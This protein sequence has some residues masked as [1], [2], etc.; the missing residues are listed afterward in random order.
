MAARFLHA[1]LPAVLALVT[2]SGAQDVRGEPDGRFLALGGSQQRVELRE[3]AN[4]QRV[5]VI[6]PGVGEVRSLALAPVGLLAAVGN[7]LAS[8]GDAPGRGV[9]Q[10]VT[11]SSATRGGSAVGSV[12]HPGNL[13]LV[14]ALHDFDRQV[15]TF[16]DWNEDEGL[17]LASR[18]L[19][20]PH[21][22]EL[23]PD[24]NSDRLGSVVEL[25]RTLVGLP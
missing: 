10:R 3:T 24:V 23:S 17:R 12:F 7:R 16:E 6:D 2:W 14:R 11:V 15:A 18:P 9:R 5:R 20:L 1:W 13:R 8:A 19:P 25:G 21:A 22:A 4:W